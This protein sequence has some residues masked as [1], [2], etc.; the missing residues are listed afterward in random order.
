[1][2]KYVQ[3]RL[4]NKLKN[5]YSAPPAIIFEEVPYSVG[6][7]D[8]IVVNVSKKYW[9]RRLNTLK[10]SISK[11]Y[12]LKVYLK[13]RELKKINENI[14]IEQFNHNTAFV[15]QS[16][17]WLIKNNFLERKKEM[18]QPK[19]KLMKHITSV[20]AFELKLSKWRTALNQAF[21]AKAYSNIQ[22][23]IMDD[24]YVKQ[25]LKAKTLFEKYDVG[26]ISVSPISKF[27]VHFYPKKQKPFSPYNLW[28]LNEYSINHL[29]KKKNDITL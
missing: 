29:L 1:M 17:N 10:K 21:A 9:C 25:A 16:V 7:T 18:I 5:I 28:K 13:I 12:Y 3:K 22:F 11:D 19:Y 2:K 20:C 26:L 8:L 14:F 23:V 24:T 6:I 27:K 4:I 15:R